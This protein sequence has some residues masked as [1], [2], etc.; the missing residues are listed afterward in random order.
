MNTINGILMV[1]CTK[2]L[3]LIDHGKYRKTFYV[4]HRIPHR[5]N[6]HFQAYTTTIERYNIILHL[7]LYKHSYFLSVN[8]LLY[9]EI[10]QRKKIEGK[11]KMIYLN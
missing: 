4:S 7:C 8:L 2:S 11:N 9:T 5:L 10:Q 6:N 1:Y 3:R